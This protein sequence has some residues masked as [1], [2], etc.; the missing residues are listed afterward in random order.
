M[1]SERRG[2]RR[3]VR[4]LLARTCRAPLGAVGIEQGLG[5]KRLRHDVG[6]ESDNIARHTTACPWVFVKSQQ[7]SFVRS[8]PRSCVL[9][10]VPAAQGVTH[11]QGWHVSVFGE[12]DKTSLYVKYVVFAFVAPDVRHIPVCLCA[13]SQSKQSRGVAQPNP[14]RQLCIPGPVAVHLMDEHGVDNGRRLKILFCFWSGIA[15][16]QRGLGRVGALLP[17]WRREHTLGGL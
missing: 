6:V 14:E 15:E 3:G 1:V 16:Q 10:A 17:V 12:C 5:R 7:G 11:D 9:L 4:G 2:D 8:C 13:A